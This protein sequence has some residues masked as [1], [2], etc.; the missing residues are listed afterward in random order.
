VDAL[1]ARLAD[2]PDDACAEH[3]AALVRAV[4]P[5][6][7]SDVET[8]VHNIVALTQRLRERPEWAAALKHCLREQFRRRTHVRAYVEPGI[9]STEGL[10]HNIKLRI[11]HKVLPE[12]PDERSLYDLAAQV[13]DD[14][15]DHRWVDG[16]AERIWLDLIAAIDFQKDRDRS[17]PRIA[18]DRLLEAVEVLAHRI[19]AVGVEPELLRN[20]PDMHLFARPFVAQ[21]D[22]A[23]RFVTTYRHTLIEGGDPEDEK[24]LLVLL[25]QCK[26]VVARV[27]RDAQKRGASVALTWHLVR[28]TQQIKR[29]EALL[30]ILSPSR[31]EG[32]YRA[33][34]RLCRDIVRAASRRNS[35]RD[36]LGETTDLLAMRVAA[37]AARTGEHYITTTRQE[38]W[39]MAR[40][41]MGAG[42]IVP[43]MALA[44]AA[45]HAL[46]LPPLPQT[47]AY[48]VNYAVGFVI[49]HLLHF[50]L[51]TKQPAMTATALARSLGESD[52]QSNLEGLADTCV[53]VVRSQL[54]AIVG[55]VAVAIP[56]AAAA[57]T[58]LWALDP[59]TMAIA[60]PKYFLVD[61]DP[62]AS[63]AFLHAA[64]AGVCLFTAGI[65]SGFYD[66]ACAY[67]D[68]PARLAAL[69]WLRRLIGPARA[70]HLAA[71]VDRNAGAL[72]GNVVLGFLLAGMGLV[73]WLTGLPI[74]I[75]HVTFSAANFG[76]ALAWIQEVPPWLELVWVVVG[77][78]GI[79]VINLVVSF[80][81]ATYLAMRS[82]H[83]PMSRARRLLGLLWD[84]LR[85]HPS[86]FVRPPP[87]PATSIS[88]NAA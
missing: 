58:A 17:G 36:L 72:A 57:A 83:V 22:E 82:H 80:G 13:F 28:L 49:L 32:D 2:A 37:N 43:L 87:E 9:L 18:Y 24:H 47:I 55:N 27:R 73:G 84:R 30:G 42:A 81:L 65:F 10:F 34:W 20:Y 64:I 33:P 56:V 15:D 54:V 45:L 69:G 66:N 12:V 39:R 40:A 79:G 61:I 35:V 44:K 38:Y 16:V 4:R 25:G 1:L 85:A 70:D 86:S 19:A 76:I 68:V 21:A 46:H 88:P 11:S 75:R 77:I 74:D 67:N 23:Q 41:A 26:G 48:G 63:R 3:L 50:A 31:A 59:R 5:R 51:A 71:Y 78:I 14:P 62:T 29:M 8:A 7:S 60:D 53:R 52:D 6:V